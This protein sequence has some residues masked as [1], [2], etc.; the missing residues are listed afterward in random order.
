MKIGIRFVTLVVLSLSL[1]ACLMTRNQ[2]REQTQKEELNVTRAEKQ[3][4]MVDMDEGLRLLRG[5]LEVLENERN[6]RAQ[7][8]QQV[9]EEQAVE[10]KRVDERFRL[11]QEALT[12]I[13]K[14]INDLILQ[15]EELK[16]K[17][18]ETLIN[19]VD[20]K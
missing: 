7:Q 12:S 9:E 20:L 13:E 10:Q 19:G 5:R 8:D 4:T 6:V 14:K 1:S 18:K 15:V 2:I 11:F 3:A 17:L 16:R